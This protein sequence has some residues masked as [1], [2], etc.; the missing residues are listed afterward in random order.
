[1]KSFT[2]HEYE[3][4]IDDNDNSIRKF[5]LNGELIEYPDP[6]NIKKGD[7]VYYDRHNQNVGIVIECNRMDRFFRLFDVFDM[8]LERIEEVTEFQIYNISEG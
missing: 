5:Y 6:S 1:M 4:E 3:I 2:E 8:K 7:L